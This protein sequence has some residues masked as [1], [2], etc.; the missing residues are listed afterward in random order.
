MVG[1]II[2][3]SFLLIRA[4]GVFLSIA[5]ML[6]GG[7]GGNWTRR[8]SFIIKHLALFVPTS[9]RM[10]FNLSYSANSDF[11]RHSVLDST[12]DLT[13]L[14]WWGDYHISFLCKMSSASFEHL[15]LDRRCILLWSC[16]F[17]FRSRTRVNNCTRDGDQKMIIKQPGHEN[18]AISGSQEPK[19]GPP[20]KTVS[21]KELE[22]PS[23]LRA[24]VLDVKCCHAFNKKSPGPLRLRWNPYNK[25]LDCPWATC[26]L[27]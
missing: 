5:W 14:R 9:C 25:L 16:S 8:I 17:R 27:R 11:L 12:K 3:L 23:R 21:E 7:G 26:V 24:L 10:S 20:R 22:D 15:Y 18:E 2:G 4:L 1:Q 13:Q 6:N 19:T